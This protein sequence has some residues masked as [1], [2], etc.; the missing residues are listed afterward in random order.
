[1]KKEKEGNTI[2]PAARFPLSSLDLSKFILMECETDV[3]TYLQAFF[4]KGV[5][6]N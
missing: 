5:Q 2:G 6:K 1:V 3:H 4:Q